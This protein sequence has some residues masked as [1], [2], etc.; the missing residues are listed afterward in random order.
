LSVLE[1]KYG[2]VGRPNLTI[3]RGNKYSLWWKDLVGL[4]GERGLVGDWTQNI[5][6]K[7]LG[8][9]ETTKFRHDKWVGPAPL[10]E[11]FPRLFQQVSL[12]PVL[13]IKEMGVW[14]DDNW[15]WRLTW[16]RYFFSWEEDL[17]KHLLEVIGTTPIK[18]VA[19]S[20]SYAF[21]DMYT[22][23]ANYLFLLGKFFL[24]FRFCLPG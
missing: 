24:P 20:W 23:S 7:K 11:I 22:V 19:D 14:E 5:F 2:G 3:G 15:L 9:G 1:A 10:C 4:G 21:G 8:S 16:R 17:Y 18:K 12:Q 6:I 13:T